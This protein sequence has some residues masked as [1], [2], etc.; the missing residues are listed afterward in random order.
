MFDFGSDGHLAIV[1]VAGGAQRLLRND[2]GKFTDV[3][4]QS[5]DLA[6][7]RD[8]VA[9]AVVAGDY[10]ND[11]RPDLFVL[12]YGKSSLYHNDGGGRFTD[13][14]A[15]AKIPES[16]NLYRSV[17]FVD[18]DHDGD[19]DI[20]IGGGEEPSEALKMEES[21]EEHPPNTLNPMA[22]GPTPIAGLLLRNN[23][24]GTFTD[25]TL[26]ARLLF[27]MPSDSV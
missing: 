8:G 21:L 17:A 2:G 7:D 15:S 5:G 3:T 20:F 4:N 1:D 16:K 26:A 18:Y 24:D 27:P 14:T 10:D 25:E 19:L 12:R 6:K 9:T 22:V 13:V 23:G 11:G